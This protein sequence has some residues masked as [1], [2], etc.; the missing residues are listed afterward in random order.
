MN[1]MSMWKSIRF[2]KN[3][4]NGRKGLKWWILW[5]VTFSVWLSKAE[6]VFVGWEPTRPCDSWLTD[7]F[8]SCITLS[9]EIWWNDLVACCIMLPA[10]VWSADLV[11]DCIMLSAETWS[12]GTL[13]WSFFE[14]AGNG[15]VPWLNGKPGISPVIFVIDSC[16]IQD[17]IMRYI[18]RKGRK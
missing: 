14:V 4:I 12:V 13:L 16:K 15:N 10:D 7:L 3:Q 18:Y 5:K 9:W 2:T 17:F 1:I 6:P 11:A 8:A